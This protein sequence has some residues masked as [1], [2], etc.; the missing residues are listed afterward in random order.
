MKNKKHHN[1]EHNPEENVKLY[2]ELHWQVLLTWIK[3]V[4]HVYWTVTKFVMQYGF[5]LTISNVVPGPHRHIKG[6]ERIRLFMHFVHKIGEI[7]D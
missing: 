5:P 1:G 3:F 4:S 2:Y 7:H 6:V